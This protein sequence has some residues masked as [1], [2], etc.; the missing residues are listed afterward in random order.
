MFKEKITFKDMP[1]LLEGQSEVINRLTFGMSDEKVREGVSFIANFKEVKYA[2]SSKT[3]LY[4]VLGGNLYANVP[5]GKY[6]RSD[7]PFYDAHFNNNTNIVIEKD[8]VSMNVALITSVRA[9]ADQPE[10]EGESIGTVS[11][12]IACAITQYNDY[13]FMN[14]KGKWKKAL[15]KDF[16]EFFNELIRHYGYGYYRSNKEKTISVYQGNITRNGK[17]ALN[18]IEVDEAWSDDVNNGMISDFARD[19]AYDNV[20]E[21]PNMRTRRIIDIYE[22][23]GV[24]VFENRTGNKTSELLGL[25]E[26]VRFSRS[27]KK[28]K[29]V[30]KLIKDYGIGSG[31]RVDKIQVPAE[32]IY[33]VDIIERLRD[34]NRNWTYGREKYLFILDLV[35]KDN[36]P[37]LYLVRRYKLTGDFIGS[38]MVSEYIQDYVAFLQPG[39]KIEVS[40]ELATAGYS[41]K[42]P[43]NQKDFYQGKLLKNHINLE[44]APILK[45]MKD[46]LVK[47]DHGTL[48]MMITELLSGNYM[49]S[50]IKSP[51]GYTVSKL[52]E[53]P[54]INIYGSVT[55]RI[56][57]LYGRIDEDS[58]NFQKIVGLTSAQAEE[59]NKRAY[60][61]L[62]PYAAL[63]KIFYKPTEAYKEKDVPFEVSSPI[64][65]SNEYNR[66]I[67]RDEQYVSITEIALEDMSEVLDSIEE[68]V[69]KVLLRLGS[70]D[71]DLMYLINMISQIFYRD[72]TRKEK[73]GMTQFLVDLMTSNQVFRGYRGY[74]PISSLYHLSTYMSMYDRYTRLKETN[75][76]DITVDIEFYT[77]RADIIDDR[78][79]IMTDIVSSITE[80]ARN[81]ELAEK[82]KVVVEENKDL[83]FEYKGL[84]IKVP[85]KSSD[86]Y[87]EG[88]VLSHCVAGYVDR[89]A[90]RRTDILM[91]RDSEELDTPFYT[92]EV[93]DDR[94]IQVRGKFNCA[95]T[96]K[97]SD[98]VREF[99]KTVL[100]D[101]I[102]SK[103]KKRG[104]A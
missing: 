23:D 71:N 34:A 57:S 88:T 90:N 16:K 5:I 52:I 76:E 54:K 40:R 64:F 68:V 45:Y 67:P 63:L 46:T 6:N 36:L 37:P 18:F 89:V 7:A 22:N 25:I 35:E 9:I 98:F 72:M 70:L 77:D 29:E 14:S 24:K 47:Y 81:I 82:F 73:L 104:L 38:S 95:P 61:G 100:R 97:V 59:I 39:K 103:T 27:T 75:P 83:E 32:N 101:R 62:I 26:S 92:M 31:L 80:E 74:S 42:R 55:R 13:Y 78:I 2:Y 17:E 4:Y 12:P 86:I 10:Y 93:R 49:E 84:E 50:L 8:G 99:Q 21:R 85:E 43:A 20:M 102:E 41:V 53:T 3:E 96:P 87:A 58:T 51:L 60:S 65:S 79:K 28:E 15:V 33:D 48:V 19:L 11:A 91:I 69:E 56:S 1:E 30:N 94:V 44:T 66:L